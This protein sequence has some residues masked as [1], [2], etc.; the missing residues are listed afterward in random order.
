MTDPQLPANAD[1]VVV[2]AG[3]VGLATARAIQLTEPDLSVV[4]VDKEPTVAGHQS[5][6]N[7]GVIHA[8]LYYAPGSQKA[9]LCRTGRNELMDWCDRHDV[10]W[11][12][13][14]KVVI[15]T[16]DGEIAQLDALAERAAA[17]G[18]ATVR[19]DR[20]GLAEIE[21]HATGLAALHV[22][23]TAI[24]DYRAVCA[25]LAAG[26]VERGGHVVL[27]TRVDAIDRP[28]APGVDGRTGGEIV[29]HTSGG[30]IRASR[31]ANCAG[32]ATDRVARAAGDE[33]GAAI[34][35]FRGEYQE[36]IPARR[37]L[38]RTLIYPVPDPRFPFL[39][40]H[41]TSM[42]DGSV[43]AGPN[44]VLA[45]AREGYRWRDVDRRDLAA[46]AGDASSWR[47]ARRYWRTG[48]G[49]VGRSLSRERFVRALQRLVP[50]LTLE[51]LVPAGSGVRAQAVRPDGTLLDDFAFA[52][53]GREPRVVH[54]VNAPSPAATASLAIGRVVASRLLDD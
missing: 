17:N 19:L 25:T 7:S 44:A 52:G 1:V 43:H 45:L 41:L 54:V 53:D 31:L 40:V 37:H 11:R 47:L 49:E 46:M 48:L 32:L 51:D 24:V 33:P 3:I 26:I 22:P 16:T 35:P 20:D 36:L 4:V 13:C 38:V 5:G 23:S 21:P 8:G 27:G 29:V 42:I 50:E 30:V 6:H 9:E 2:G 18:I 10:P 15:A 39:G 12:R 34:L 28:S 14:G